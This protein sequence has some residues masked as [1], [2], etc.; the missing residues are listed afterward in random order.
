MYY[1]GVAWEKTNTFQFLMCTSNYATAATANASGAP[2]TP[3]ARTPATPAVDS[4]SLRPTAT[5][6]E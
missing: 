2:V 3:H 6:K 4:P 5:V 1:W